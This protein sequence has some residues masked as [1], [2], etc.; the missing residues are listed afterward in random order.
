MLLQC[1]RGGFSAGGDA[2]FRKDHREVLLD[3]DGRYPELDRYILI[4]ETACNGSEDR[5]LLF[6]QWRGRRIA[7]HRFDDFRR[8]GGAPF[9]YAL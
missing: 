8:E 1:N 6:G 4:A 7:F 9:L 3:A 5:H 2:E